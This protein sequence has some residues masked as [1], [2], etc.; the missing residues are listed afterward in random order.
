MSNKKVEKDTKK[1]V[2]KTSFIKK[3]LN[4]LRGKKPDKIAGD[5]PNGDGRM[6]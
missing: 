2:E 4:K 6:C 3:I 1:K 5:L